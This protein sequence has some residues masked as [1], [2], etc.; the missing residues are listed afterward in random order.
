MMTKL[1]SIIFLV[2]SIGILFS[3]VTTLQPSKTIAQSADTCA[4]N[5]SSCGSGRT[6]QPGS[7]PKKIDE[8][9]PILSKVIIPF[10]EGMSALVGVVVVLSIIISGIQ[11]SSARDNPQMVAAAKNRIVMSLLALLFFMFSAAFL[12]WLTPGGLFR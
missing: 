12:N 1:K 2:L 9:N 8:D 5:P 7:G 3:F 6:I 11:Y 10:T 4:R